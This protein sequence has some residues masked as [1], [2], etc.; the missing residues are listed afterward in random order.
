MYTKSVS[1]EDDEP[2]KNFEYCG[3]NGIYVGFNT[4]RRLKRYTHNNKTA[5]TFVQRVD[6]IMGETNLEENNL[7]DRLL[8]SIFNDASIGADTLSRI[9]LVTSE[10]ESEYDKTK[11][12]ETFV[13]YLDS[14]EIYQKKY[15]NVMETKSH[16]IKLYYTKK[17]GVI[18][19]T[20]NQGKKIVLS[21]WE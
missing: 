8:I 15:Y 12:N 2:N 13:S 17:E 10:K 19:F 5:I 18:S 16:Q 9:Y 11:L 3:D 1:I 4:E 20:D 7:V 6:F 21:H 14:I